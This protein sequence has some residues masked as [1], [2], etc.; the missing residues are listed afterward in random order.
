EVSGI[1]TLPFQLGA[2]PDSFRYDREVP[3]YGINV[4]VE[5]PAPG[6][7][8]TSDTVV[9]QTHRPRYWN[10]PGPA[11]VL[12]FAKLAED[13]LPELTALVDALAAYDEAHW[14]PAVLDARQA[15]EG[16]TAGMRAEA[17]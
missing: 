14:S 17:D 3:A 1:S 7:L 13:P 4:G 12:T 5:V 16:W 8:R 11:P 2:L 15:A 9:V 6:V 10:G